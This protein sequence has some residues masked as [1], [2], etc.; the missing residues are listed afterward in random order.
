MAAADPRAVVVDFAVGDGE[1]GALESLD[2]GAAEGL[3]GAGGAAGGCGRAEERSRRRIVVGRGC[4]GGWA[5][6][7]PEVGIK[8]GP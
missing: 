5:T 8:D 4:Y 6:M 2:A 7:P 1:G 3:P